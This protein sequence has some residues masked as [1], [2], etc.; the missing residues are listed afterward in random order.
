MLDGALCPP[1]LAFERLPDEPG[2]LID[3]AFEVKRAAL[4]PHIERRWS[5]DEMFQREVHARR[6]QEKPFTR[7]LW[8]E[9]PVGTI[10]LMA[11]PDH[12]RLGEFYL[13]PPFQ[14]RGLG[15]VIL[16]HCLALTDRAGLPVKLEYLAWNRVGV[17]YGRHGF[18]EVSRSDIHVFMERPVSTPSP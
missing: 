15:S 3:F 6:W 11:L 17:L 13:L 4:G 2:A 1:D 8:R 12:A 14:G 18:H 9:K 10:S 16:Q 5:W 7:I